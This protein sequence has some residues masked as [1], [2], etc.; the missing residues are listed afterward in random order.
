MQNGSM[1][2]RPH[3]RQQSPAQ[4]LKAD[5]APQGER[6]LHVAELTRAPLFGSA[7]QILCQHPCLNATTFVELAEVGHRLLNDAT[8]DTHAAHQP[9]TA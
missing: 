5:P 9:P 8:T 7:D 6:Q 3:G 2:I 1:K 4:F